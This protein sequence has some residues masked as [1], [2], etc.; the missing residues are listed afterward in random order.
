MRKKSIVVLVF[1]ATLAC[2]VLPSDAQQT[3]SATNL[4]VSDNGRYVVRASDGSPVFLLGDTVWTFVHLLNREEII[5]YLDNRLANEFN[6]IFLSG[7]SER[8]GEGPNAYGD[9]PYVNNDFTRPLVTKGNNPDNPEEYDF[10]D[11]VEFFLQEAAVRGMYVALNPIYSAWHLKGGRKD[12]RVTAE[13]CESV[14]RHWG[15]RFG[16]FDNIIWIM[17]GDIRP[18]HSPDHLGIHRKMARGTAIGVS[19]SEDY[20]KLLMSFH[21]PGRAT[22]STWFHDDPWLDFN[23]H[24]TGQSDV[25][26]YEPISADYDRKPVKPVLDAEP[27]Y[28][29]LP[30]HI[31]NGHREATD[32]DVRKRA[33][34]AVFAGAFGHIYGE[35]SVMLLLSPSVEPYAGIAAAH[36][37]EALNRPGTL[38]MKYLRRL[39]ES[40]PML[41]RVPDQTMLA[42]DPLTFNDRLQ[43]TKGSDYLFVYSTGGNVIDLN[44]G[45]IS[46]ASLRGWWFNPRDGSATEIGVFP[47]TGKARF[48]PP[49]RGIGHDWVLVLDDVAKNY[50]APGRRSMARQP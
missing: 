14:A 29:N 5:H 20:T 24:Q 4:K 38:Q 49:T 39:V 9:M 32:F 8:G 2:L 12:G 27:W 25:P 30:N 47:N 18:D 45:G 36:W 23:M 40:R 34:W 46:G 31:R 26:A 6:L 22:S 48:Q 15:E 28:E 21:P 11:H 42:A 41:M 43:A 16:R 35:L 19:G 13:N 7:I 10:W 3:P 37:K 1:A 17:G 33:Y 44:M 50:P